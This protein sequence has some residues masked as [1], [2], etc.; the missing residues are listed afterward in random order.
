MAS[1]ESIEHV[2]SHWHRLIENFETSASDFYEA[3]EAAVARR[4][5]PDYRTERVVYS[6]AGFMSARREYLRVRR[7]LL[8]VDICAA[9]FG[10]GYF[11][12]SWLVRKPPTWLVG[13]I[14]GIVLV[15]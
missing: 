1:E 4:E 5:V 15:L 13:C 9:P 10:T 14:L 7:G 12:S 6:E 2:V 11:F 3:V 8:H